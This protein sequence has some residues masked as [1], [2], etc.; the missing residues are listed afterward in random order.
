MFFIFYCLKSK[1]GINFKEVWI[2]STF[3]TIIYKEEVR[4]G[5]TLLSTLNQITLT[6]NRERLDNIN[7][8]MQGRF[9]LSWYVWLNNNIIIFKF[10]SN[11]FLPRVIIDPHN[12]QLPVGLTAQQAGHYTGITELRIQIPIR[13]EFFL[14][15]YYI[16]YTV[17]KINRIKKTARITHF[18]QG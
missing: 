7:S 13:S 4:Q 16:I 15:C 17:G 6:S 14:N 5:L 18:K 9:L 12:D 2:Y 1:F 3:I 8:S 11:S 10:F